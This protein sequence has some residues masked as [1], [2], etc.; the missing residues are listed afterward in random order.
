MAEMS[1][2][3]EYYEALQRALVQQR[4]LVLQARE[5]VD[6]AREAYRV[7]AIEEETLQTLKDKRKEQYREEVRKHE[8]KVLDEIVTQ[9]HNRPKPTDGR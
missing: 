1:S 3:G 2:L 9:R 6:A 8:R 7:Q 4:L 5:A